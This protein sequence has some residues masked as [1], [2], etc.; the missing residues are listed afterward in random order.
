MDWLELLF[1]LA[2]VDTDRRS[3]PYEP[4]LTLDLRDE[5]CVRCRQAMRYSSPGADGVPTCAACREAI[6]RPQSTRA[7]PVDSQPME[8]AQVANI[9]IDRCPSCGGVWLDGGELELVT[10]AAVQA[11]QRSPEEA[12]DLLATVLVGLPARKTPVKDELL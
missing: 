12:G 2:D 1:D 11:A 10:T 9:A 6:A 7:C 8:A 5:Q 4:P 3:R